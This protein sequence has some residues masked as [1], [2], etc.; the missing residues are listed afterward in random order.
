MQLLLLNEYFTLTNDLVFKLVMTSL[1]HAL[2]KAESPALVFLSIRKLSNPK[3]RSE[4]VFGL[5]IPYF[6]ELS[7]SLP[8]GLPHCGQ[9]ILP[10]N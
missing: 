7:P 6:L 1:P 5:T 9:K 10:V 4:S 8:G 2:G 3:I